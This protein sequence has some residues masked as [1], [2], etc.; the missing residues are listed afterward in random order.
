MINAGARAHPA[1]DEI[2]RYGTVVLAMRR[3]AREPLKLLGET[4]LPDAKVMMFLHSANRDDK[5]F[6]DPERFDIG[7]RPNRHLSLGHGLHRC[8]GSWLLKAEIA[9]ILE[10][11]LAHMDEIELAPASRTDFALCG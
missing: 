2:P 3:S 9:V 10:Q 5:E 7:R 8:L 11:T 6:R 1:V 4:L